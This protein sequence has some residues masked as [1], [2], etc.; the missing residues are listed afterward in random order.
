MLDNI[1]SGSE[2]AFRTLRKRPSFVVIAVFTLAIGIGA[3]TAIFSVVNGVLL[4]PLPY[5][6]PERLVVLSG[7]S[8][9]VPETLVSYLDY[10]EWRERQTVFE[11]IA[12]RMPAGFVFTGEGEPER[13]IGRWVSA[14]FFQ[15]TWS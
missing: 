5:P 2:F 6:H 12:V 3:N 10:L 7:T 11:D 4:K 1:F 13:I 15:N 9:E 14:S 8:R